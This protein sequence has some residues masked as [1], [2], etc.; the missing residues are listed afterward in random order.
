MSSTSWASV[1]RARR[2]RAI[3]ASSLLRDLLMDDPSWTDDVIERVL[4]AIRT[5]APD[6]VD[7]VVH[8][9]LKEMR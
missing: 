3:C 7:E 8:R 2:R 6:E 5:N 1:A 4:E 9:I